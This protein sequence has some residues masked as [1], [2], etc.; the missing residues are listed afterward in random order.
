MKKKKSFVGI[1]IAIV[2]LA[3]IICLA[4]VIIKNWQSDNPSN[5]INPGTTTGNN[6]NNTEIEQKGWDTQI[7]VDLASNDVPIPSGFSIAQDD[8]NSGV[9]V[10]DEESGMQFAPPSVQL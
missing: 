1:V 2:I 4:F 8:S 7:V 10:Q 6:A 9:I 5:T 3:I